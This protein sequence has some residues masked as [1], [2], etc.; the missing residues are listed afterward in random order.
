MGRVEQRIE[1][2]VLEL[3]GGATVPPG[4]SI[5][6]LLTWSDHPCGVIGRP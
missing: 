6:D 1:E 2:L 5:P 4:F 3:P